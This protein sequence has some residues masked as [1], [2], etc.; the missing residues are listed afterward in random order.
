[1]IYLLMAIE[2]TK[3]LVGE[4]TSY[5]MGGG[6]I[7]AWIHT[8]PRDGIIWSW[9][10][11]NKWEH[12]KEEDISIDKVFSLSNRYTF[13]TYDAATTSEI[14]CLNNVIQ[15]KEGNINNNTLL[16]INSNQFE[17]FE[18][19]FDTRNFTIHNNSEYLDITPIPEDI[20]KITNQV[21]QD[22][23][24]YIVELFFFPNSNS[25]KYLLIDSI[26]LQDV[27]QRENAAI[28]TGHGIETSGIPNRRF[29]KED[30]LYL[31]KDQLQ[32][33][34]KF[35]NG[36]I[37]QDAGVYSTTL[38]SRD[39]VITSGIMELSGGSRLNYRLSPSWGTTNTGNTKANFNN[40]ES[41]EL[42]N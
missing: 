10:S 26:E 29:V 22:D 14:I 13:Q 36:L 38:A 28:G 8:Q 18:I 32:N 41:V 35:Y 31:T 20:Y 3:A 17:T 42:D 21:N 27:T 11:N 4:E 1:M 9:T 25:Q 6:R 24:N 40:F 39:A 30:K 33:T 2:E 5:L 23:T 7:G 34:L 19:N 37:G 12:V 15:L 16:N